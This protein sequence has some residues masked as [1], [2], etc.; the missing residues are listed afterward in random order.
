M[1]KTRMQGVEE[2]LRSGNVCL[3]NHTITECE[4]SFLVKGQLRE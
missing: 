1:G 3:N 4:Y 2:L